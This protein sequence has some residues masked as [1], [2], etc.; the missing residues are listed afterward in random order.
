MK[1]FTD[2]QN[3]SDFKN[4]CRTKLDCP[5]KCCNCNMPFTDENVRDKEEWSNVFRK[6]ICGKCHEEIVDH[7][8]G[9]S[10]V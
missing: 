6:G 2:I 3:E 10:S 9:D 1:R 8:S 5:K 4:Y 7:E